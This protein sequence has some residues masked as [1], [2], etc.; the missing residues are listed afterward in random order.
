MRSVYN[1]R[2]LESVQAAAFFS[3]PQTQ[4]V[5]LLAST[6]ENRLYYMDSL[7]AVAM[8][9]GLVL[10]AAVV[11]EMWAYDPLR[12]H[13]QPS[14]ALHY[15]MEMIHVF[16]MELFFL[17][18]GFFSALVCCRRGKAS[19]A[20]NRIQRILIPFVLCVT[21]LMPWVAA[22]TWLDIEGSQ[23]SITSKYG[24]M[25][26]DPSYIIR[27]GGPVGNW[28]WH[29]W[30]LHV[31]C[32][33]IAIYLLASWC[34]EKLD[35]RVPFTAS[36]LHLLGK[37][38]GMMLLVIPTFAVLIF[39]P[40]WAD[41]PGVGTSL[42][43][44]TYYALFFFVGVL[45]NSKPIVLDELARNF[46]YYAV[47][48]AVALV[49]LIPLIDK[50][51]LT[52]PPELMLQD[53]SL[54]VGVEGKAN[55]IGTVP[56]LQNPF[57]FSSLNASPEWFA[58]CFLRAF[59]TWSAISGFVLIFRTYCNQP[60]ALGRY[61]ADSSYFVYLAHFPIQLALASIL[62]DR[63]NSA[64]LCFWICLLVSLLICVLLYHFTCRATPLGRLL[65]GRTYSLSFSD[66]W[67]EIRGL[68][69][70]RTFTIGVTVLVFGSLVI[71]WIENQ[72]DIRLLWMSHH[73]Q[74]ARVQDY[75]AGKSGEELI[76]MVRPDGRNA[77]H[78]AAQAMSI[79]RPDDDVVSTLT[80]LINA[81]IPADSLDN[82]GQSPLHYSI[83]TGNLV[84]LKTLLKFKANPNIPDR[85]HGLTPLHLAATFNADEMMLELTKA[86]AD[87]AQTR[88]N[89]ESAIDILKRFHKREWNSLTVDKSE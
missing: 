5:T 79:P 87:P 10:H 41:V 88:R 31:L 73:A 37:P 35:V 4:K 78:M 17:V 62:R 21:F 7:R 75:V 34:I 23:Q 28:F 51:T 9:L 80:V 64:F 45:L 68:V 48:F 44:L 6:S 29:F 46:K 14:A 33:F 47:P 49:L 24:E 81:G 25:F 52:S 8:F 53:W 63:I 26:V 54:F 84:A 82:F 85:V 1:R 30:F 43:V 69:K 27:M 72:R 56:L 76:T 57:N 40:P 12:I 13:D 55:L 65:S 67:S 19:Y 61:A 3:I 50:V 60:S 18:A 42:D 74:V 36:L 58:M 59:C 11:F 16:R 15:I 77:L 71:G 20:K 86:G 70:S 39:S 83:R 89:G 38:W 66:E 22:L 2:R 32:Y